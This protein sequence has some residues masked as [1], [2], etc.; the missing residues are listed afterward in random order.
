ME[1][2]KG[3]QVLKIEYTEMP[4]THCGKTVEVEV[5]SFEHT[6][7]F[8]VFCPLTDCEDRYAMTL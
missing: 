3:D 1:F 8:N 2:D 5:G 6:G 4:C 7:V